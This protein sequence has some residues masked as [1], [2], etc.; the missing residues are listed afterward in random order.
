M[1]VAPSPWLPFLRVGSDPFCLEADQ[2]RVLLACEITNGSAVLDSL[3]G[4][5]KAKLHLTRRFISKVVPAIAR[6]CGPGA[7]FWAAFAGLGNS[8]LAGAGLFALS[9]L[10]RSLPTPYGAF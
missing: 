3:V 6:R 4:F 2:S 9:G 5:L 1:L 7:G 8:V 10:D